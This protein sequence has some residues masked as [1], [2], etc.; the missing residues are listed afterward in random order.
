M[1]ALTKEN[2]SKTDATAKV[3]LLAP[4][5]PNTLVNGRMICKM[6]RVRRLGQKAQSLLVNIRKVKSQVLVSIT[7]KKVHSIRVNG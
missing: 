2:G 5:M 4:R 3:H 6:D 7:G 1:E